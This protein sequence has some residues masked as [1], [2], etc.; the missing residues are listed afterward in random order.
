MSFESEVKDTGQ[1]EEAKRHLKKGRV[2]RGGWRTQR[3]NDV[4]KKVLRASGTV[5]LAV[6]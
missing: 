6:W 4:R 2:N 5:P 3:E 1:K